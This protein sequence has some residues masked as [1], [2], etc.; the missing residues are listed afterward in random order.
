MIKINLKFQNEYLPF[1]KE[2]I[3][4]LKKFENLQAKWRRVL[5]NDLKIENEKNPIK[6]KNIKSNQIKSNQIKMKVKI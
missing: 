2:E 5:K 4:K 3:Q 1:E 6:S